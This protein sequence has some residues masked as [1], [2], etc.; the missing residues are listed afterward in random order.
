MRYDI[1][2]GEQDK[3]TTVL[4]DDYGIRRPSVCD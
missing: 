2:E 3:K 4:W 1:D